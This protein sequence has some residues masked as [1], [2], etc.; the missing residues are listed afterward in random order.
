MQE[1]YSRQMLFEPI[2]EEGQRRIMNSAVLIVGMGAL[3]TVLANHMVRAGVG[4]VRIVD[5][6][7]VEMS[8]LQRQLLYDEEDAK[9]VYPKV[10]AAEIK[11]R[12]INSSI[13]IEAIVSDVTGANIEALMEG[14]DLVLDGTDN[15]R[16]RFLLNDACFRSGIPFIYGGA[17]GSRG[18]SA[19][20]VPGVTPCL[21][22]F[23]QSADT[24]GETCD[25]I[26]VIAPVVD[27][28][29]SYEAVEALKL[30]AGDN[31]S[32]KNSLVTFD[33]WQNRYY[34]MKFGE[35][36]RNCPCCQL[37]L[38]PALQGHEEDMLTM[39]GRDSVQFAGNGPLDLSLW[40]GRLD[41]ALL[42]VKANPYL[43]RAEMPGGERLV[44]FADGR[45]LVQGT[46]DFSRARTLY[47]RYVGT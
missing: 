8:N 35:P 30:L 39:C 46:D 40:Q 17:V 16:T 11:L 33:L 15:F 43:L 29:A 7:F 24:A 20:F 25:M 41:G 13:A 28:A 44:L 42:K 2:G 23:I 36:D 10:V 31:S 32:R 4:R 38:Y 5:R 18:M 34:E 12:K 19:V 1:R 26:G 3:G 22:C 9:N 27:I 45:V 14:M 37:Q 6:D 21:R 47:D